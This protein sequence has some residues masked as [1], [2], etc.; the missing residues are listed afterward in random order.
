MTE[1]QEAMAEQGNKGRTYAGFN[2]RWD[3]STRPSMRSRKRSACSTRT[4]RANERSSVASSPRLDQWLPGQRPATSL[5]EPVTWLLAVAVA[6]L[7]LA[8]WYGLRGE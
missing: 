1:K 5:E 6:L 8:L 3:K 2:E 4:K 7:V